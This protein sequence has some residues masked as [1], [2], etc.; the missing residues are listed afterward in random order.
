[1]DISFTNGW[2]LGEEQWKRVV[3]AKG[4]WSKIGI[5]LKTNSP[6]AGIQEYIK[7]ERETSGT[8]AL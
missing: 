7:Y 2:V 6:V 8:N 4:D 3:E 1:M 5:I